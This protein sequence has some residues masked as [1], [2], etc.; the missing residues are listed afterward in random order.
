MGTWICTVPLLLIWG[1]ILR[2]D[3]NFRRIGVLELILLGVGCFWTGW[4]QETLAATLLRTGMNVLYL[5]VLFLVLRL[6]FCIRERGW[7]PIV[8][9]L[10]GKGDLYFALA[11]TPLFAPDRFIWIFPYTLV[12]TIACFAWN[13]PKSHRTLPLAGGQS[14]ALAIYVL[15]DGLI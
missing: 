11:I 2:Q 15:L 10:L 1:Q 4:M 12:F 9:R 3:V 13:R 14:L 5:S 8:D 7:K 6:Y